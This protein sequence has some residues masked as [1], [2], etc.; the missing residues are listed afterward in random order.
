M[1]IDLNK[2]EDFVGY[3]EVCNSIE[4]C[5]QT[6]RKAKNFGS[7]SDTGYN[8]ITLHL[9]GCKTPVTHR[10][11]RAVFQATTGKRIPK[12]IH[13]M[14]LND[15]RD[16]NRFCNLR[17]GTASENNLMKTNVAPRA[18]PNTKTAIWAVDSQ[19]NRQRFDSHSQCARTL[20]GCRPSI[21]K[22]LDTREHLRYYKHFWAN[23]EKYSI[24]KA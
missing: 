2:L 24:I 8:N 19:G 17:L 4:G 11:H 16:D 14:H 5:F 23:G 21:G 10:V 20:G 18:V 3:E 1:P 12:G 22:V 13:C 9:K 15:I 6:A 7:R